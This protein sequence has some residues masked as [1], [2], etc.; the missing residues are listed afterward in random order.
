MHIRVLCV[1][2]S[3]GDTDWQVYW[4]DKSLYLRRKWAAQTFL[5]YIGRHSDDIQLCNCDRRFHTLAHSSH[6]KACNICLFDCSILSP[7]LPMWILLKEK[8]YWFPF[9][10]E[11]NHPNITEILLERTEILNW[12]TLRHY[13]IDTQSHRHWWRSLKGTDWKPLDSLQISK[14]AVSITS[15]KDW[16]DALK[17]VQLP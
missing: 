4:I 5:L 11:S 7:P 9:N 14:D 2:Y 17:T 10:I 13:H 12:K 3:S 8:K 1:V 16:I 6:D 15:G